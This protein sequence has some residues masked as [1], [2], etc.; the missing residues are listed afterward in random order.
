MHEELDKFDEPVN[1]SKSITFILGSECSAHVLD[2]VADKR[3]CIVYN[4]SQDPAIDHYPRD[5]SL[6]N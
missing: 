3:D 2:E 6:L 5:S 1:S 4:Q